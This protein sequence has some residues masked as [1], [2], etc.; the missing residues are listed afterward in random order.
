MELTETIMYH[1][2]V[3]LKESIDGLVWN[4]AGIYVD[5]TFGGGGHSRAIRERLAEGGRLI[6]FDQDPEAAANTGET[7]VEFVAANFRFLK[8][9]L[10]LY[11]APRVHGIL[12]DLG[13]S[14][15]QFDQPERGF[16]TRFAGP[17]DMRM[18]TG[19]PL[20]AREVI[21]EYS[22]ARLHRLLGMYGEV[23]NARTL[24]QAIVAERVQQPITTVEDLKRVLARFSPKGREARYYA[25]VFQALRIEVNDELGALREMLEQCAEVLVPGGR[26]VLISYH[27]LEDRLVKNMMSKGSLTGEVTQDFYGNILRPFR[28]VTKKPVVPSAEEIAANN[29]ARSAKL[30]VAERTLD[31]GSDDAPPRI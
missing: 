26:L 19:G 3:L 13:V 22:E 7:E 16:S 11:G 15:H 23:R 25:Q 30:R 31:T 8:R 20:T 5:L 12:G 9:Y 14:S 24:A 1:Q 2:P 10:K 17:L 6:A 29:R 28:P 18:D 27:S 21:N 4:P